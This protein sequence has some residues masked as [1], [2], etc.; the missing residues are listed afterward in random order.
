MISLPLSLSLSFSFSFSLPLKCKKVRIDQI[1]SG[2]SDSDSD[3]DMSC[4]KN[5]NL[6]ND[7]NDSQNNERSSK[8]S[9][10]NDNNYLDR[11]NNSRKNIIN[12]S[13]DS[14]DIRILKNKI[15][16]ESR[17]EKYDKQKRQ[18]VCQSMITEKQERNMIEKNKSKCEDDNIVSSNYRRKWKKRKTK[19]MKK[20]LLSLE[21]RRPVVDSYPEHSSNLCV[22][23]SLPTFSLGD[24]KNDDDDDH[25]DDNDY[26][27]SRDCP[28]HID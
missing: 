23:R 22:K 7:N 27:G 26:H 15:I 18:I 6:N 1:K 17:K 4:N 12:G 5:D 13:Y 19:N 21:P 10:I 14:A 2:D 9:K 16:N 8:V 11:N 28:I 20:K 3:S 25:D 24:N